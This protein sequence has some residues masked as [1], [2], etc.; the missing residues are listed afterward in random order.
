MTLLGIIVAAAVTLGGIFA[1]ISYSLFRLQRQAGH[2]L[3]QKFADANQIIQTGR[4]P[5][6]WTQQGRRQ[7]EKLRHQGRTAGAAARVGNRVQQRCLH[8]LR[9]LVHFLE[10]G[11]F[12]DSLE[13]RE[14]L[15]E[16]LW[17]IHEQWRADSWEHFLAN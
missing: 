5:T 13:T 16:K 7:I 4:P 6:A 12:Y 10:N 8:R 14:Q 17:E 9:A 15:V 11:R 2:Q 3:E 1:L